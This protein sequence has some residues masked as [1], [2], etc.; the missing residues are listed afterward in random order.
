MQR[1]LCRMCMYHAT[2]WNCTVLL[3]CPQVPS[4]VHQ[5]WMYL[6]TLVLC[7]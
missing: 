2:T 6:I 5:G 7:R 3:L 1:L 4:G